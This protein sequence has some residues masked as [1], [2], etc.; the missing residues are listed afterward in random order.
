MVPNMARINRESCL[1]AGIC[2]GKRIVPDRTVG[3]ARRLFPVG[4]YFL[5]CA[6]R[7]SIRLTMVRAGMRSTRVTTS[8]TSSGAIIQLVRS[9]EHTSELQS[10][11]YL[12][13]RLLL[14]KRQQ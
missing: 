11:M 7:I 14:E 3:D 1:S 5:G 12:V 9:E 8:A 10:P 2:M 4:G 6:G 13:C